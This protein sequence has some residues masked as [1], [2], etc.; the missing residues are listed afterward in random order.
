MPPT[1]IPYGQVPIMPTKKHFNM[2]IIPLVLAVLFF[3]GAAGFGVWAFTERNT[4]KLETNK[5]VEKE[6]AI[7]VEKNSTEKD[8]EFLEKEKNPLKLYTGPSA[9]G[10][11]AFEYPKTWS[12]HINEAGTGNTPLLGYLHPNIVPVLDD[13]TSF[14]LRFEVVQ[15]GFD[16]EVAKFDADVKQGKT[17]VEPFK[18]EGVP[19]VTGSRITG[20]ITDKKEGIMVLFPVR[21]KTLRVWTESKDFIPDL[22]KII[23]KSLVFVP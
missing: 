9:F 18:I 11:V 21:D 20:K 2:L 8:N 5:V 7:A 1:G 13:K 3:L 6:V 15:S 19:E 4:Y 12:A 23:L 14:A 17:S 16:R 22:D 10:T